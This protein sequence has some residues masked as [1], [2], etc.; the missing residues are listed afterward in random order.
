MRWLVEIVYND[1]AVDPLGAS[2]LGDIGDLGI[3]QVEFVKSLRNYII[4]TSSAVTES[5]LERAC[6][7]LLADTQIQQYSFVKVDDNIEYNTELANN[8]N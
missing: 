7:E 2:V 4:D 6:Q 8:T 5:D 1:N 3:E